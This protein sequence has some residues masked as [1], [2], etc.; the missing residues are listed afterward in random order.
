M[1]G[2]TSAKPAQLG[3]IFVFCF[4]FLCISASGLVCWCFFGREQ[5]GEDDDA[6]C[7]CRG[8]SVLVFNLFNLCLE[9]ESFLSLHEFFWKVRT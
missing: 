9:I 5:G 8:V 1:D 3:I 7:C 4:F 2:F 6:E